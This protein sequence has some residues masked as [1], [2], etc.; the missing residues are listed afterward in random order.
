MQTSFDQKGSQELQSRPPTYAS[1]RSDTQRTG[2]NVLTCL[3]IILACGERSVTANATPSPRQPSCRPSRR[4][5]MN[6]RYAA[7]A[8]VA[9]AAAPTATPFQWNR[10][11]LG[12]RSN[13]VK[14]TSQAA[15]T[16][17]YPQKTNQ[18]V[19]NAS[20]SDEDDE[21]KPPPLRVPKQK[22]TPWDNL[23]LMADQVKSRIDDT[24]DDITP[25]SPFETASAGDAEEIVGISDTSAE[26]DL[27]DA[28]RE[29]DEAEILLRQAEEEAARYER[30][31]AEIE[32]ASES[33]KSATNGDD[34]DDSA[35][36]PPPLSEADALTSMTT[37][38]Q[39]ALDAANE[40]VDLLSAQI[41]ALEVELRTTITKMEK[42]EEDKQRISAEYAFLTKNYNT[43]KG[44][45]SSSEELLGGEIAN[46]QAK[47]LDLESELNGMESSLS[48]AKA[49]ATKW[50][51]E[52]D[53]IQAQ[54]TDAAAAASKDKEALEIKVLE[55]Q[56]S[57]E[58]EK[59]AV[60]QQANESI[61]RLRS[62]FEITLS[63]SQKMVAAL[64]QSLRKTRREKSFLEVKSSEEQH[65]AV[66]SVRKAM[67][68]EVAN[69]K[70]VLKNVQSE[71]EEKDS[72]LV[73]AEN[74]RVETEKLMDDLK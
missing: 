29:A 6:F 22:A 15:A 31:L 23:R 44:K 37:A 36:A 8:L 48:N 35:A 16:A 71:M 28:Q 66:E 49:D 30:E 13:I 2:F 50:K 62:E 45:S 38:Y 70:N 7:A 54:L 19:L 4:A 27:A 57:L 46:F 26:E 12:R 14:D 40:N 25:P 51:S 24:L 60:Q 9:A 47:I 65:K 63:N 21:I 58:E 56:A 55:T 33:F 68:D 1:P 34:G 11:A 17:A 10:L 3:D 73:E 53:Q 69:L 20:P 18:F 64:R 59:V 52:Y 61:D 43:L 5:K 41:E 67:D 39:E 74:E 72:V 42:T 32:A